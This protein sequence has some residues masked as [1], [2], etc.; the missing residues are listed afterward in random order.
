MENPY[1]APGTQ[2]TGTATE[3]DIAA[4]VPPLLSRI[5]GGATALAGAIVGLTGAQTLLIVTVR[6]PM[7]SAPWI[8]G[9]IGLA[10]IVIAVPVFRAR[11]WSV[12]LAIGSSTLLAITSTVWLVFSVAHGLFSL[13]AL[14]APLGSVA[15]IVLAVLSVGPSQRATS[16]RE[17]LKAQGMNLGI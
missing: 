17:R 4:A 12:V 6:G 8:L 5:A 3:D 2:P 11:A 15:A 16:A 13:V 7:A 14:G 1:A 9:A 10:E